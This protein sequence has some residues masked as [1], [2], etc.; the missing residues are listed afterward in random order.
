[1]KKIENTL[2]LLLPIYWWFKYLRLIINLSVL[3]VFDKNVRKTS[4]RWIPVL[5][6]SQVYTAAK[7]CTVWQHQAAGWVRTEIHT[8]PKAKLRLSE[9]DLPQVGPFL[10]SK[11]HHGSQS[12]D[13]SSYESKHIWP[14]IFFIWVV[15]LQHKYTPNILD[16]QL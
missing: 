6:T 13:F 16:T 2:S 14:D 11:W 12:Q 10:I 1:M 4:F 8:C 7:L 9:K 3:L 5:I 15:S